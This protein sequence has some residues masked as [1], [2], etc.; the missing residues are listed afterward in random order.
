MKFLCESSSQN[1]RPSSHKYLLLKNEHNQY[2]SSAFPIS[3]CYCS[4]YAIFW[5]LWGLLKKC[6]SPQMLLWTATIV[7]IYMRLHDSF[8]LLPLLFW[9]IQ[10]ETIKSHFLPIDLLFLFCISSTS[11]LVQ[12]YNIPFEGFP[13]I[14][15]HAFLFLLCL[16]ISSSFPLIKHC[17]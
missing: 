12:F 14:S 8:Q 16:L 1:I 2:F 7:T 11:W 9:L 6:S 4:R 10:N 17:P 15:P 13:P 3:L 5:P